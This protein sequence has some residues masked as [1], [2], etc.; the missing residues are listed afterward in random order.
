MLYHRPHICEVSHLQNNKWNHLFS[1]LV[2]FFPTHNFLPPRPIKSEWI[3]T[4]QY[5]NLITTH[6]YIAVN[7]NLFLPFWNEPSNKFLF[8]QS[9]QWQK[10]R[11][12]IY[13][14]SNLWIGRVMAALLFILSQCVKEILIFILISTYTNLRSNTDPGLRV[15]WKKIWCQ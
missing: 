7:S 1:N 13:I 8:L 10:K 15:T 4:S 3:L 5:H 14:K 2:L 11:V 12:T 6:S 9:L